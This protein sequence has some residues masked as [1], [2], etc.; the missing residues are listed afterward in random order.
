[1]MNEKELIREIANELGLAVKENPDK[2]LLADKINELIHHD[3]Q[4]LIAILYRIDISETKLKLLLKDNPNSDAGLII[5]D[6]MIE[7]QGQKIKSRKETKSNDEIPD[8]EK[9]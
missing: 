6:M 1:M 3:F 8:D 4:R 7:R 9:W 2:Q 5:A